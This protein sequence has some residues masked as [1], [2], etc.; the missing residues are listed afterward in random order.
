MAA[1]RAFEGRQAFRQYLFVD[2][3]TRMA[4]STLNFDH[5]RASQPLLKVTIPPGLKHP[6]QLRLGSPNDVNQ[7]TAHDSDRRPVLRW[8][9]RAW[10]PREESR[11]FCGAGHLESIARGSFSGRGCPS[12]DDGMRDA[13][14]TAGDDKIA[15]AAS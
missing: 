9:S 4:A 1:S 12:R 11:S 14:P 10:L 2:T 13:G 5:P 6:C 3:V 8:H 7:P 15:R